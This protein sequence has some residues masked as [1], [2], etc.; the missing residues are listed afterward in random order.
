MA[1]AS[2][3]PLTNNEAEYLALVEG[4]SVAAAEK[5]HALTV[6]GDS[7]LVISQV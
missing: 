2:S 4:M 5:A 1:G 3:V 7:K 6:V